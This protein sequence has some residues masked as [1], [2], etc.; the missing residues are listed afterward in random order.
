MDQIGQPKNINWC[1]A[2]KTC[3]DKPETV[4]TLCLTRYETPIIETKEAVVEFSWI[5]LGI[6]FIIAILIFWLFHRFWF[7]RMV[8]SHLTSILK[9]YVIRENVDFDRNNIKVI[10]TKK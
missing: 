7:R 5:Y 2:C 6:S 3:Y 1:K 4:N 8:E 9:D 10:I